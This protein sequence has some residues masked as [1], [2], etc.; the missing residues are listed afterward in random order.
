MAL[1]YIFHL[2]AVDWK[3]KVQVMANPE[4]EAKGLDKEDWFTAPR[5]FTNLDDNRYL[6]TKHGWPQHVPKEP[7]T[8]AKW[9]TWIK[10]NEPDITSCPSYFRQYTSVGAQKLKDIKER[11]DVG[12]TKVFKMK[13]NDFADMERATG[14][15]NSANK[16][17]G[18]KWSEKCE[19]MKWTNAPD[20]I[21]SVNLIVDPIT[22]TGGTRQD[23]NGY[24]KH[25]R[26]DYNEKPTAS[27]NSYG[28]PVSASTATS[29][30]ATSFPPPKT[31]ND[32]KDCEACIRANGQ[33]HVT[34]KT[35]VELHA[36]GVQGPFIEKIGGSPPSCAKNFPRS[37]DF[38][39]YG[40]GESDVSDSQ[41]IDENDSLDLS[42]EGDNRDQD[43]DLSSADFQQQSDHDLVNEA[44]KFEEQALSGQD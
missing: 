23:F 44:T 1:A 6:L 8:D 12:A 13:Y 35:C 5:T 11:E 20:D 15:Y 25:Y 33:F 38:Q 7:G 42:D 36:P 40:S 10:E 29:S 16:Q 24:Y 27:F 22:I 2:D 17:A 32:R 41:P 31:G 4:L 18:G 30:T 3:A 9:S 39:Q 28:L 43:G 37:A 34:K 21:T 14:R 19:D 26:P